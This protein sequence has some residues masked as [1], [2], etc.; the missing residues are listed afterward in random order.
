MNVVGRE[1]LLGLWKI[2][3]LYHAAER[4]LVGLWLLRELRQH[5]YEVSPGTLYPLLQRMVEH[6]WL[7]CR[8][9]PAGGPRARKSY[10]L[11]ARGAEVLELVCGQVE[12]LARELRPFARSRATRRGRGGKR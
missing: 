10:S 12:E 6:G 9:A 2:H 8:V 11:T 3:I 7:R 5:G 1:I 4:P